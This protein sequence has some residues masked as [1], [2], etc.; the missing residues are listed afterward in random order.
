MTDTHN[1]MVL[2]QSKDFKYKQIQLRSL[3]RL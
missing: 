2:S 3:L 1:A